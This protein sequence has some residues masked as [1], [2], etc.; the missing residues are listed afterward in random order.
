MLGCPNCP[1]QGNKDDLA[2]KANREAVRFVLACSNGHLD[3]VPWRL[4]VYHKTRDCDSRS[5]RWKNAGGGLRNVELECLV[6]G[7]LGNFGRAY[8]ARW[9]CTGCYPEDLVSS[10]SRCSKSAQITQRLAVNLRMAE[11]IQVLTIPPTD[12]PVHRILL[13]TRLYHDTIIHPV[14]SKKELMATARS[15]LNN[16]MMDGATY[17]RLDS[18]DEGPILE[19]IKD[20]DSLRHSQT[21]STM[22]ELKAIELRELQKAGKYGHSRNKDPERYFEVY[23]SDV[24][25]VTSSN[26]TTYRVVPIRRLRFVTI[27]TGYKRISTSPTESRSVETS[28]IDRTGRLGF[29]GMELFGE[30]LFIELE[31]W[32]GQFPR[33]GP[34]SSS[35]STDPSRDPLVN[36]AEFVWWHTFSHRL[37]NSLAID[38]G[39]SATSIRE[40]VYPRLLSQSN[41]ASGGVLLYTSQPASD[42]SLGGLVSQG[43]RFSQIL[44]TAL[45][46]LDNCSNDPLCIDSRFEPGKANGAACYAC[47]LVSETACEAFNRSLDRNIL[48]ENPP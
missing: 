34:I 9:P 18:Q 22:S 23:T 14:T 41:S 2:T 13:T 28:I 38:S 12:G 46:S 26:N 24:R 15:F 45:Y 1:R 16:G 3:E 27:Q 39:Y 32:V 7:G 21:G 33:P 37:I 31:G 8:G 6:C 40:R 44:D 42:G 48:L 10:P 47:E 5:Y 35:W 4:L 17:K 19:A 30:G 11:T 29:A 43:S 20:L 25:K 36:W